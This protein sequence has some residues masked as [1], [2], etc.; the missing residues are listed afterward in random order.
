MYNNQRRYSLRFFMSVR[1]MSRMASA[2]FFLFLYK[3]HL[4]KTFLNSHLLFVKNLAV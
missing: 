3:T 2:S 4:V 1:D